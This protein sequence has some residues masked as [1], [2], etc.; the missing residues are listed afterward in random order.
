VARQYDKIEEIKKQIDKGDMPLSSYTIIHRDAKLTDAEK[1]IIITWS[2]NIRKD[3]EAKYP[4]DSLIR[5]KN[6]GPTA[7]S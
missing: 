2:E 3:M 4:K 1:N 6:P 7:G 5:K